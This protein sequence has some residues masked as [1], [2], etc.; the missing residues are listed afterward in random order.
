VDILPCDFVVFAA[1]GTRNFIDA[2][3][4]PAIGADDV[5]GF[6]IDRRRADD[7]LAIGEGQRSLFGKDNGRAFD[8]VFDAINLIKDEDSGVV[9]AQIAG[10]FGRDH[11]QAATGEAP[12]HH[13][14]A[15]I[16][17]LVAG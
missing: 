5:A 1:I 12:R 8:A 17:E 9:R 14:V 4:R 15:V 7:D 16:F 11:F 6:L 3:V 10:S 13:R 2:L